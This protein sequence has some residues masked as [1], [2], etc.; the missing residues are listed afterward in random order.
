MKW[1]FHFWT[2]PRPRTM[3][4]F[5]TRVLSA[6]AFGLIVG[7]LLCVLF[8]TLVLHRLPRGPEFL[9][10]M[11]ISSQFSLSYYATCGLGLQL[12]RDYLEGLPPSFRRWVMILGGAIGAALGFIIAT[13]KVAFFTGI[14]VVGR[15][16]FPVILVFEAISGAL[17]ALVVGAFHRLR[18]QVQRAE[19]D[20]RQQELLAAQAQALALQAQIQPH[21]FF[22]TLN[23]ISALISI[24]PQAAQDA[25]GRLADMFR[26]ALDCSQGNL[27]TLEE[28]LV[29]ASNYLKLEQ[30]RFSSRLR[31][32]LP[33]QPLNDVRL[34]GLTLQPLVENAVRHGISRLV[35]G[36][37][38]EVEVHRN[39]VSCEV[40]VSNPMEGRLDTERLWRPGHALYNVRERLRL[41]GGANASVAIAQTGDQVRVVLKL[42]L[43]TPA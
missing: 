15:E 13:W 1:V 4:Q 38:V 8:V 32:V 39:G 11:V 19:S 9:A 26:Y 43:E 25:V 24:N 22:N 17:I 2:A 12:L 21:F 23:T 35:D 33:E 31:V 41:H 18:V 34:P 7:F 5:A 28:E 6:I 29:F 36:G 30:A 20:A 40:M 14:E 3:L 10:S 37:T 16:Y 42:P 27:R